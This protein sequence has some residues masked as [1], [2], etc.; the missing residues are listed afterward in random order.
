[1]IIKCKITLYIQKVYQTVI[2]VSKNF[3]IKNFQ[4]NLD[5]IFQKN[6]YI[7]QRKF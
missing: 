7:F 3:S 4:K 1:M 5:I 6:L 2:L